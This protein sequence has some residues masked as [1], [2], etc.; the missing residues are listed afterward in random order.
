MEKMFEDDKDKLEEIL[1]IRNE[2]SLYIS[3][4]IEPIFINR[5]TKEKNS[6]SVVPFE[7]LEPMARRKKWFH[8]KQKGNEMRSFSFET[9][10][11]VP[12]KSVLIRFYTNS[13][14]V[15]IEKGNDLEKIFNSLRKEVKKYILSKMYE[16]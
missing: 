7:D 3:E 13:A 10:Y 11:S 15:E 14:V 12:D 6:G 16:G 2:I 1:K 5:Y 4:K 9:Y 8:Y